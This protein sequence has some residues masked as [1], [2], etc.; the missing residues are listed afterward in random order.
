MNTDWIR[1]RQIRIFGHHGVFA[2]ERALG[3]I[4][5]VDV[6]LN[7]DTHAAATSD[8]VQ[9]TV[10]YVE[11]YHVVERI[12]AGPSCS[13][14]ETMLERIADEILR[15]FPV[16]EAVIRIRKP[17]ARMPGPVGVVEVEIRRRK[18]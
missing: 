15:T 13:L 3:Q 5:E 18:S 14:I 1:L 6:E 16:Y 7:V 11:V 8:T 2:D 4:F 17:Q 10:D 9:D 12:V